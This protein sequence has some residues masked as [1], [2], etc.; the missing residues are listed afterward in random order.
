MSLSQEA[1]KRRNRL[2]RARRE[3]LEVNL[4]AGQ[5]RPYSRRR[6]DHAYKSI[7]T[8][9]RI[10]VP[11]FGAAGVKKQVMKVPNHEVGIA[12]G[13]TQSFTPGRHFENNVAI[14]QQPEQFEADKAAP[15]AEVRYS[16]WPRQACDR[17]HG[18]RII[19]PEQRWRTRRL[20]HQVATATPQIRK[21]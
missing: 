20:Q 11:A 18:L 2:H 16:L 17:D 15:A 9:H 5:A 1:C 13:R 14:E 8:A 7:A 12:F 21:A 10:G 6:R 3:L 4:G 19:D